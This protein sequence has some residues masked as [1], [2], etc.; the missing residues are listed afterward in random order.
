MKTSKSNSIRIF[1]AAVRKSYAA[2]GRNFCI[3]VNS[4]RAVAQLIRAA[5]RTP[6][7]VRTERDFSDFQLVLSLSFKVFL[8][9]L[10]L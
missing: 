5:V 2:A 8:V 9:Y 3:P 10:Y 4:T 1:L 7:R 6:E